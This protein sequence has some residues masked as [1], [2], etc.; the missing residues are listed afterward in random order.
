MRGAVDP[1][2]NMSSLRGVWLSTET[3]LPLPGNQLF[4]VI[5]RFGPIYFVARVRIH[6]PY[7]LQVKDKAARLNNIY[8]M[9]INEGHISVLVAKQWWIEIMSHSVLSD[10][11]PGN[12]VAESHI[13]H[14]NTMWR[15]KCTEAR[16]KH[17]KLKLSLCFKWASRHEGILGEWRYSSMHFWLRL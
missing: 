11:Y 10:T 7:L 8:T 1:L 17:V 9:N 16:R 13:I 5:W 12:S 6:L 2:P 4:S 15:S 14:L 3:H